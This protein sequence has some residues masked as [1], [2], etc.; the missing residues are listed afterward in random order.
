[1]PPPQMTSLPRSH[2]YNAG[3]HHVCLYDTQYAYAI[4]IFNVIILNLFIYFYEYAS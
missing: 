1:M 4:L 3:Y 2:P